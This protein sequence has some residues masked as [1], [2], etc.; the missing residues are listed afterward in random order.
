MAH[1]G[2]QYLR[3]VYIEESPTLLNTAPGLPDVDGWSASSSDV[4]KTLKRKT[5]SSFN[6]VEQSFTPKTAQPNEK[7]PKRV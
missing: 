7:L 5:Q 1:N 6:Y 2:P 4:L 3:P